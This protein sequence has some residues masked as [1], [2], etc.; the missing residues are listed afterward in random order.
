MILPQNTALNLCCGARRT[1]NLCH[2]PIIVMSVWHVER[3][4]P[5]VA[6]RIPFGSTVMIAGIQA[7]W[8]PNTIQL[9][10]KQLGCEACSLAGF[11]L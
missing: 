4:S 10:D 3:N 1:A 7:Y 2:A 5:E 8:R 11:E 6:E 9:K